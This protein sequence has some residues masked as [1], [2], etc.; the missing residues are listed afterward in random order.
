MRPS[1]YQTKGH[2]LLH[3][4]MF[5]N[6]QFTASERFL[7]YVQVDTQSDPLSNTQPT[8]EKQKDLEEGGY[9]IPNI[10][11]GASKEERET[12]MKAGEGKPWASIQYHQTMENNMVMN[13]I[14]GFIVNVIV[15]YLFCWLVMR[16]RTPTFSS[17]FASALVVALIIFMNAPY[18]GFIWYESFD[19]WAY[20][21]DYVVSWGLV[22][23]WLGWFLTRNKSKVESVK[24]KEHP[25]EMAG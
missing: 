2:L 7:R 21:L 13:M 11:P 8:T 17:I 12:K 6:Y 9:I 16:L 25:M 15:V 10:P 14:R 1:N 23:L 20:F 19:I 24:I 18:V 3:L 4:L 5:Q 22:G